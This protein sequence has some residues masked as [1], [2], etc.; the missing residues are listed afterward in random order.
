V[1]GE[2]V[3]A[4]RYFYDYLLHLKRKNLN[5]NEKFVNWTFRFFM[6]KPT[7]CILFVNDAGEILKRRQELTK[8]EI[9]EIINRGRE[10]GKKLKKFI[11]IKTD[12]I[13]EKVAI[14]CAQWLVCNNSN[15]NG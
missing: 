15:L 5:V 7:A 8:D 9:E 11:E 2:I 14:Q 13:P 3:I 1:K 6:P 4:E 10:Y 12:I